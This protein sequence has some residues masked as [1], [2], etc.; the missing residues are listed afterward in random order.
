MVDALVNVNFRAL[1]DVR[2]MPLAS[3]PSGPPEI[4]FRR[5]EQMVL[6]M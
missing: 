5:E 1:L 4:V 2:L 6:A 3:K